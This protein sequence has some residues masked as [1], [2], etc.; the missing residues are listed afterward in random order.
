MTS[1]IQPQALG[2][3]V[4]KLSCAHA[5]AGRGLLGLVFLSQKETPGEKALPPAPL[6]HAPFLIG[7][8]ET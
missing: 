4:G 2:G 6:A 5:A 8:P 1:K 3:R 7:A